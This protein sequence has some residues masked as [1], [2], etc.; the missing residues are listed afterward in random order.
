MHTIQSERDEIL[1]DYKSKLSLI[2]LPL[3]HVFHGL[4]EFNFL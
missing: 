3:S 4:H 2:K 1:A